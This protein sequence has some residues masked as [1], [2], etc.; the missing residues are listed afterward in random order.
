ML[1]S[2]L[3]TCK[4]SQ[5][6]ITTAAMCNT[7]NRTN[8]HCNVNQSAPAAEG[9]GIITTSTCGVFKS[10]R[11]KQ[12]TQRVSHISAT[13]NATAPNMIC[14]TDSPPKTEGCAVSAGFCPCVAELPPCLTGLLSVLFALRSEFSL[15][16]LP[17]SCWS[18][19]VLLPPHRA[20]SKVITC[21][22][23]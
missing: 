11:V 19:S 15:T 12:H 1:Q 4:P 13:N 6:H 9:I 18:M 8:S 3:F 21:S 7:C 5:N 22:R 14:C 23:Q 10:T 16:L 20:F 17:S 2:H